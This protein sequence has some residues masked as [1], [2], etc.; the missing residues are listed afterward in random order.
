MCELKM[1]TACDRSL[2]VAASDRRGRHGH[3]CHGR[4]IRVTSSNGNLLSIGHT[5]IARVVKCDLFFK[6]EPPLTSHRLLAPRDAGGNVYPRHLQLFSQLTRH[7]ML[8]GPPVLLSASCRA[9]IS[10]G[11]RSLPAEKALAAA[12]IFSATAFARWLGRL[13]PAFLKRPE[14]IKNWPTA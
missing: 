1:R 13:K 11:G 2:T 5:R 14:E 4:S 12:R 10:T 9:R 7:V 8:A 6:I 3:S